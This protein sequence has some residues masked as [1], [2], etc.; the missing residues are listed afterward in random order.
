MEI[1][2][3]FL[4]F[5]AMT[6]GVGLHLNRLAEATCVSAHCVCFGGLVRGVN[7]LLSRVSDF[8][9]NFKQYAWPFFSHMRLSSWL[10]VQAGKKNY[11]T[12]SHAIYCKIVLSVYQRLSIRLSMI[13]E[14]MGTGTVFLNK[15][16]HRDRSDVVTLKRLDVR[17]ALMLRCTFFGMFRRFT[18]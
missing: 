10:Q 6:C 13:C 12:F 17:P 8:I 9:I 4:L 1:W 5:P 15:R 2:I 14:L 7:Y 3:T 16:L 18:M 11:C